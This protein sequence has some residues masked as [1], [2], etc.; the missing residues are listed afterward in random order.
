MSAGD[1][2][3]FGDRDGFHSIPKS[4][5]DKLNDKLDKVV[6]SLNNLSEAQRS[7]LTKLLDKNLWK[8]LQ[9]SARREKNP[10]DKALEGLTKVQKAQ[11]KK[12]DEQISLSKSLLRTY[13]KQLELAKTNVNEQ[14]KFLK[15]MQQNKTKGALDMNAAAY[16]SEM[17]KYQNKHFGSSLADLLMSEDAP[18]IP[19]RALQ[20]ITGRNP[21]ASSSAKK[22]RM[23]DRSKINNIYDRRHRAITENAFAE[24]VLGVDAAKDKRGLEESIYTSSF[25]RE[26]VIRD[27]FGDNAAKKE[28]QKQRAKNN[29]KKSK[30]QPAESDVVELPAYYGTPALYLGAKLDFISEQTGKIAQAAMD[31]AQF[32]KLQNQ[33]GLDDLLTGGG[34]GG[35]MGLV[36]KLIPML[37]GLLPVFA[38]LAG[39]AA[40]AAIVAGGL[41][42][43]KKQMDAE[44]KA[45][46]DQQAA[47][48][49]ALPA[50][51][52]AALAAAGAERNAAAS[53]LVAPGSGAEAGVGFLSQANPGYMAGGYTTEGK[54]D[55]AL[56]G[57]ALAKAGFL[58][59]GT[60]SFSDKF[61]NKIR[62]GLTE[63]STQSLTDSDKI[64]IM[65]STPGWEKAVIGDW[66]RKGGFLDKYAVK[67]LP[68]FHTGGKVDGKSG[69]ERLIK[70]LPGERVL[71]LAET[72]Q[73]EAEDKT[74]KID[75]SKMEGLLSQI[76]SLQSELLTEMQKNTK[77]TEE[78]ELV[79]PESKSTSGVKPTRNFVTA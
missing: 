22:Q 36:S 34:V 37:T 51:S 79:I 39:G 62:S 57:S 25:S 35:L 32:E 19:G 77:V 33:K 30:V 20:L 63:M 60:R 46:D 61:G 28:Q 1:D 9:D 59:V 53:L 58:T 45:Y 24:S 29:F 7:M 52:K 64:E 2:D 55:P 21:R 4:D 68:K 16:T 38:V 76:A 65:R 43:I 49:G 66:D 18:Y 42:A 23:S 14:E 74:T 69:E 41:D 8:T 48:V 56:R 40:I 47:R 50:S 17:R 31:S 70:A 6:D 44:K 3:I 26:G 10:Y 71:N 78:K 5:M 15:Y 54:D 73:Y 12:I 75:T 11:L 72:A 27:F 67:G 13:Q